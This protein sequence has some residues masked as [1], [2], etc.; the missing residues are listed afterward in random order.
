MLV[1]EVLGSF[2]CDLSYNDIPSKVLLRAKYSI[3]DTFGVILAGSRAD[4]SKQ[5]LNFVKMVGG[6]KESIIFGS[7]FIVPAQLAATVN[8]TLGHVDELNDAMVKDMGLTYQHLKN[9]G[10]VIEP[11]KYRKYLEKG[12]NTPTG[13]VELY[14]ARFE[15]YGYDPLPVFHEPPESPVSTPELL[16]EYPLILITGGRSIAFFN[17]EGRQISGLRKRLPDPLLDIH[18]DTAEETGITEGDW[19]WLETPQVRGERIRLK[20]RLTTDVHPKVVHAPHGWWFPE[21]PAPEHGCFDSNVNVVLSGDPPREP[22]C[23]SVRTRG[24]LCKIY[25]DTSESA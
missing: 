2:A 12:F 11:M 8:G 20:A 19:V 24:T 4:I 3:L 25:R 22:I 13:K 7:N 15:E 10:Y 6:V 21:R 23:G 1:Q 18:P 9:R 5:L 16:P 17:T 14:S